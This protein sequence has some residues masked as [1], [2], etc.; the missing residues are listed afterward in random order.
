MGS[1]DGRAGLKSSTC[2]KPTSVGKTE[3][4]RKETRTPG[5]APTLL[6]AGKEKGGGTGSSWRGSWDAHGAGEPGRELCIFSHYMDN[7]TNGLDF[8]DLKNGSHST[9]L[10]LNRK[11]AIS[12]FLLMCF[13]R[14][15]SWHVLLRPLP[16]WAQ[17]NCKPN[18]TLMLMRQCASTLGLSRND[19][20]MPTA[21]QPLRTERFCWM[22]QAVT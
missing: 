21:V 20:K 12:M 3:L 18:R 5:T 17:A 1:E 9:W 4:R 10:S 2:F 16:S 6:N 8:P 22:S 15:V 7:V 14:T 19:F 13:V 11:S